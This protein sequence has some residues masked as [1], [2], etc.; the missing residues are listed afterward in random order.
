MVYYMDESMGM[1]YNVMVNGYGGNS[2]SDYNGYIEE[3]VFR[4][5]GVGCDDSLLDVMGYVICVEKSVDDKGMYVML[6]GNMVMDG[7]MM[8][9]DLGDDGEWDKIY[10]M[11][12]VGDLKCLYVE[13]LEMCIEIISDDVMDVLARMMMDYSGVEKIYENVA[14]S[15]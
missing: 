6:K 1:E 11:D 12:G 10:K 13:G 9:I 8:K 5:D 15:E 7:G 14:D 2:Y 3:Y 4:M